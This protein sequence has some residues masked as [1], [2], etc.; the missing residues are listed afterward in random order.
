MLQ[1]IYGEIEDVAYGPTWFKHNYELEW[2]RDP[3]VQEMIRNV[4]KSEYREG[5]I[6]DSPVLGPIPPVSL[7]GGVQTLIMIYERPDIMFDATS[8]GPNCAR[9][10]LEIGRKKDVTVNLRYFMPM[11]GLEP[12]DI[13]IVNADRVV[14]TAEDYAL[15]SLD[16]L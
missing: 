11:D 5:S 13:R 16:Y 14:T 6:I 9:W 10:L 12:L 7:S 2:F 8:C 1:I 3:F 15:T 4:D